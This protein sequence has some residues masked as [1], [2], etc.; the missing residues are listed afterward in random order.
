MCEVRGVREGEGEG[1]E[2]EGDEGGWVREDG[3]RGGMEGEE[4]EGERK[5]PNNFFHY[6]IQ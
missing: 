6:S 3:G 2:G 5:Y 4:G 1:D